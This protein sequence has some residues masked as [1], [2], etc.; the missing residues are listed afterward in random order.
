MW[1]LLVGVERCASPGPAPY[2]SADRSCIRSR[3]VDS[4]RGLSC[5]RSAVR[6]TVKSCVLLIGDQIDVRI[7][8]R[9]NNTSMI[10]VDVFVLHLSPV[11]F[12]SEPTSAHRS[13][14]HRD[15][16]EG[17]RLFLVSKI[18]RKDLLV[19]GQ[20]DVLEGVGLFRI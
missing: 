19:T 12:F 2:S 6:C 1:E 14:G 17:V 7:N 4:A 11:S 13:V 10:K 9:Q 3:L 8:D 5:T 16:L 18:D 20:R 15:V